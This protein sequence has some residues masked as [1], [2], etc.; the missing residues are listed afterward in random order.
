MHNKNPLC[1][2]S[3]AF[4]S[5]PGTTEKPPCSKL[6]PHPSPLAGEKGSEQR[7]L[8]MWGRPT[9]TATPRHRRVPAVR[10]CSKGRH[11]LPT[12]LSGN[13]TS[14]FPLSPRA[15]IIFLFL[16]GSFHLIF[17]FIQ[18][19]GFSPQRDDGSLSWFSFSPEDRSSGSWREG[20]LRSITLPYGQARHRL[21]P[22]HI[23]G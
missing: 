11:R 6:Q 22:A 19:P 12:G 1:K 23:T 4:P 16:L 13:F 9:G 8:R 14:S 3:F 2:R 15:K 21:P 7:A 5:R 17:C 10:G 20:F 18:Q